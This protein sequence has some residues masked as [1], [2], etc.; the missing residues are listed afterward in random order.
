MDMRER[1]KTFLWWQCSREQSI[2]ASEPNNEVFNTEQ[3]N[4]KGSTSLTKAEPKTRVSEQ[5]NY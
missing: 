5:E 3:P 2:T 1:Q 4:M